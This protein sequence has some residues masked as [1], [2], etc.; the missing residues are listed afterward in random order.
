MK[1]LLIGIIVFIFGYFLIC[2]GVSVL[3][4]VDKDNTGLTIVLSILYLS[5]IVG[6]STIAI[7]EKIS[8]QE[9]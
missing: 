9:K 7:L 5:A 2:L 4:S 6:G 3:G 8:K 1:S